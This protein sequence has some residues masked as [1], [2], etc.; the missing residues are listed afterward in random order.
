MKPTNTRLRQVLWQ[1]PPSERM[2]M[3]AISIFERDGEPLAL[4]SG[5]IEVFKA[6]SLNISAAAKI[7]MACKLR[8]LADSL[9][10]EPTRSINE[11]T[12]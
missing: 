4:T 11:K 8:D 7:N 3:L 12:G 6:A 10:F 5:L 9:E 2:A 1:L